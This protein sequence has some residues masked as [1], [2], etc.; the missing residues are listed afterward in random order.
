MKLSR[1]LQAIANLVDKDH[2]ILDIGTDHGLLPI[3]L[4]TNQI[5]K[6]AIASDIKADP[7]K[8]AQKNVI[9]ANL[10]DKIKLVLS[11]GLNNITSYFNTVIIAGV[12]PKTIISVLE[13]GKEKTKNKTLILQS[14]V[15]TH[16][17]RTWLNKN[18]FKIINEL[19]VYEKNNYY[20][21]LKAI[22]GRQILTK[23]DAYLGPLLKKDKNELISKYYSHLSNKYSKLLSRI[24]KKQVVKREELVE[25]IEIYNKKR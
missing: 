12:G 20:E 6:L 15:S 13:S 16:L 21:I 3:Y 10:I 17:V 1:R 22:Q 24:P 18:G 5:A 8:Q 14:N 19:L 23:G 2:V 9:K 4:V 11:D 25:I 7:L